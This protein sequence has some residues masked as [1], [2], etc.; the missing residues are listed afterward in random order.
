MCLGTEQD[1]NA[2]LSVN[3]ETLQYVA[4]STTV[5]NKLSTF[6]TKFSYLGYIA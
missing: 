3:R 6:E 5:H 2:Q 4:S 1:D